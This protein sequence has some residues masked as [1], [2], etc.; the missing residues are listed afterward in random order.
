MP[1]PV[2]KL[3]TD[4]ACHTT[5]ELTY[6]PTSRA[7]HRKCSTR[8]LAERIPCDPARQGREHVPS[9]SPMDPWELKRGSWKR[10]RW[11]WLVLAV[12]GCLATPAAILD[13][14]KTYRADHRLGWIV[15]L[16]FAIRFGQIW[17]FAWLWWKS[18]P[19]DVSQRPTDKAP[20]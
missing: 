16:A 1:L 9:W 5:G 7:P 20:Q 3:H 12:F 6:N 15:P 4:P 13:A 11:L 10:L 18:R 8:E 17:L 19:T 14:V 2:P